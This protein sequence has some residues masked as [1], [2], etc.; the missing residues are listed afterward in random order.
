MPDKT[1]AMPIGSSTRW[2]E[3]KNPIFV[4]DQVYF[5]EAIQEVLSQ[6][7][8][9]SVGLQ[10]RKYV[11]TSSGGVIKYDRYFMVGKDS[12]GNWLEGEQHLVAPPCPD[13]CETSYE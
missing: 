5:N 11:E 12:N 3:S 10:A 1:S 4:N 2:E 8:C 6:S 7:G 13:M 9:V